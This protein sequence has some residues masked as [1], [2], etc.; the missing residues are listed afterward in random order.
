MRKFLVPGLM[1][2]ALTGVSTI[3]LAQSTTTTPPA[4]NT[5]PVTEQAP[6]MKSEKPL[7]QTM[8][9]DRNAATNKVLTEAAAKEWLG[10]QIYSSD[11]SDIGEISGFHLSADGNVDYF[12]ADIGGFLGIGETQ[13][14]VTPAEFEMRDQKLYLSMTKEDALKL[15]RVPK[16]Q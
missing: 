3:A 10:K 7:D 2:V 8:Q 13:V 15:P 12:K 4:E 11:N 9:G 14:Q 16:T 1:A 5:P 6:A